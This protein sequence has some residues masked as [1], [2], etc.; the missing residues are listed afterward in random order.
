MENMPIEEYLA[1]LVGRDQG[2]FN[3]VLYYVS[4][5]ERSDSFEETPVW[6]LLRVH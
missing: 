6:T 2:A 5:G 1:A 3:E 4:H